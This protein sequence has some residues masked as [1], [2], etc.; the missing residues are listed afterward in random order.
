[1][2]KSYTFGQIIFALRKEYLEIEKQLEEPK[3]L[4][5]KPKKL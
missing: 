2:G 1:M 4:I 5:L 3:K